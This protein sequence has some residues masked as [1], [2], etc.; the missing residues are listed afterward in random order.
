MVKCF[1]GGRDHT[2]C[3]QRRSVSA[4]CISACR[5]VVAQP[6]ADCFTFVGNI[7]QCYEEGTNN[8]PGPIEDLHVT[9]VTN[10]SI[11]LQ[12]AASEDDVNNTE[13]KPIDF[14]VQYGKVDNMTLYETVVR[15]DNV[16]SNKIKKKLIK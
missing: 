5:G 16:S 8:I 11:S 15:L 3:C 10:T 1:A 2:P 12:W 14:L 9:T 13:S 6:P 7:I 4:H